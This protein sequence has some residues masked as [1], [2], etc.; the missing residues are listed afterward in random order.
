VNRRFPR[1]LPERRR[2]RLRLATAFS[3]AKSAALRAEAVTA[4]TGKARPW[5]RILRAA[6]AVGRW[7]PAC[8]HPNDH[9]IFPEPKE[10][11]GAMPPMGGIQLSQ[12]DIGAVAAYVWALGH[13]SAH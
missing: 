1:F 9:Q 4:R 12:V 13:Q 7:K 5:A 8:H 3:T 6:V 11:G 2:R 10:H